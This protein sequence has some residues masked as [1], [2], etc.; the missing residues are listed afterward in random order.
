MDRA[1]DYK[2]TELD[3]V[4]LLEQIVER[5]PAFHLLGVDTG[6]ETR[7][8]R[9]GRID[10]MVERDN[11]IVVVEVKRIAPQTTARLMDVLEQLRGYRNAVIRRYPR[12]PRNE[13]LSFLGSSG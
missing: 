8:G 10:L 3:L 5:D 13:I 7:M 9:R 2:F 11:V 12:R 1:D 4:L 6:V